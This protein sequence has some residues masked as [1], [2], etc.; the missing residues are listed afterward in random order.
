MHSL[1]NNDKMTY[2]NLA[3]NPKLTSN[4]FKYIAV[5]IKGVSI[6]REGVH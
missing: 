4:G 1:L 2:V 5:Y 6:H 3:N